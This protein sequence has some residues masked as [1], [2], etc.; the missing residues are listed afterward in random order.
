MHVNI[1]RCNT[2]FLFLVTTV[3]TF[4]DKPKSNDSVETDSLQQEFVQVILSVTRALSNY[5]P[6]RAAE[7]LHNISRIR[8]KT[9][10]LQKDRQFVI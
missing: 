2:Q 7:S 10:P 5:Q 4:N 3:L 1:H 8:E 9:L 6:Y